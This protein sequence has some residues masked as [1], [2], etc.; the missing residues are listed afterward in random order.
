METTLIQPDQPHDPTAWERKIPIYFICFT[1]F[2]HGH[3]DVV[4]SH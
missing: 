4:T 1:W 2:A 3:W